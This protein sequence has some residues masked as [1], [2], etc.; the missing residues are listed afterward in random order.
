[1]AKLTKKLRILIA[2]DHELIRHGI[3][4]ILR[5]RRDWI[6][7]AEAINGTQAV[8][9][10]EILQPDLA[11]LDIS[12]PEPDGLNATRLIRQA[13]PKCDVLILTMHESDLMVRRVLEAGALGYVSKADLADH[14]LKAVQSVTKGKPYLTPRV[15]EIVSQ[16]ILQTKRQSVYAN[17]TTHHPSPREAQ[18]LRLV[19]RGQSSKQIASDLGIS[20]RTVEMHRANIMRKFGLH[21]LAELIHYAVRNELS[22]GQPIEFVGTSLDVVQHAKIGH[23]R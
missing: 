20:I 14:L 2:D 5:V 18:I 15:S 7:I 6:V 16:G 13:V 22:A 11:I 3:R 23:I 21:S 10:A 1:M 8:E 4:S 9:R 12:M 19:A 17:G